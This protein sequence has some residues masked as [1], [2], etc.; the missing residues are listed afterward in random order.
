MRKNKYLSIS[1]DLDLKGGFAWKKHQ[2]ELFSSVLILLW[3]SS[4]IMI[5][6]N[7]IGFTGSKNLSI[8]CSV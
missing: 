4:W 2:D 5:V 6:E 8:G 3:S 7:F 1:G